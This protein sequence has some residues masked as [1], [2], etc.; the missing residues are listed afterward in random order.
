MIT[1]TIRRQDQST[2]W[3]EY[4]ND[5]ASCNQ[6]LKEEETR[7]YWDSTYSCEISETLPPKQEDVP[8]NISRIQ[9]YT[10]KIDPHMNEA[11]IDNMLGKP[12]KLKALLAEYQTIKAKYPKPIGTADPGDEEW[13]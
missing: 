6:W 4:F 9:A 1:L 7:P 11:I 12:E 3:T 5:M 8:W 2:Y 10:S 13:L